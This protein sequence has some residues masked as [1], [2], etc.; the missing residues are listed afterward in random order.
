MKEKIVAIIFLFSLLAGCSAFTSN[1]LKGSVNHGAYTTKVG[2]RASLAKFSVRVPKAPTTYLGFL[3]GKEI[4]GQ[5]YTILRFGPF[6]EEKTVYRMMVSVK[7]KAPLWAFKERNWPLMQA[8][9]GKT[10]ARQ[11]KLI[12]STNTY[13]KSQAA[14]SEV[15]EEQSL[16]GE[17]LDAV[18][19]VDYGKY[20]LI[21]WVQTGDQSAENRQL[22]MNGK[23]EPQMQ[24]INSFTFYR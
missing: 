10:Q 13:V 12:S 14:I 8:N 24:F 21:F 18:T 4:A 7:G 1:E 9:V 11:M 5:Y 2:K 22:V 19:F 20:G 23:W 17:E 15:Y 6:N 3:N 16:G